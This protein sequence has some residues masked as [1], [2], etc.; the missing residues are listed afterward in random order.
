[1]MGYRLRSSRIVSAV[2]ISLLAGPA[3]APKAVAGINAIDAWAIVLVPGTYTP[4]VSATT[5]ATATLAASTTSGLCVDE[6]AT[7]VSGCTVNLSIALT[8]LVCGAGFALSSGG[9]TVSIGTDSDAY[10]FD[11]VVLAGVGLVEGSMVEDGVSTGSAAGVLVVVP[12]P[13]PLETCLS[14]QHVTVSAA[15]AAVSTPI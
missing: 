13:A 8:N 14:L 1:M 5:P 11:L 10:N 15:V 9:A 6:P 4:A 3:S 7:T 2:A 12:G